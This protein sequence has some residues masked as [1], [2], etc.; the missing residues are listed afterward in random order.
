V[1]RGEGGGAA[2]ADKWAGWLGIFGVRAEEGDEVGVAGV[3]GGADAFF[4]CLGC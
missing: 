4:I 1:R 3:V 2:D